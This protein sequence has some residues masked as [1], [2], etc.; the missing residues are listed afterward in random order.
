MNDVFDALSHSAKLSCGGTLFLSFVPSRDMYCVITAL[1]F[2]GFQD[3][4]T[5]FRKLTLL[6]ETLVLAI[7]HTKKKT[8]INP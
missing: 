2:R 1:I 8:I 4:K 3:K 7:R 6:L 5:V